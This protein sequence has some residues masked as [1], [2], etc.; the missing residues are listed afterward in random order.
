MPQQKEAEGSQILIAAKVASTNWLSQCR[1]D[2]HA[3][4]KDESAE[5][6]PHTMN[7][8]AL[9]VYN[10]CCHNRV[11]LAQA[12]SINRACVPTKAKT[13]WETYW[14]GKGAD[15]GQRRRIRALVFCAC[16]NALST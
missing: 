5:A 2:G 1:T 4:Q 10:T 12:A 7:F 8:H 13:I 9:L 14:H 6:L 16:I 15:D 3:T 11:P